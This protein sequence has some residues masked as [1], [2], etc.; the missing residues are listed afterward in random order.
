M[1]NL[2][3]S[4]LNSTLERYE[5]TI[6]ALEAT[7]SPSRE[8]ILDVLT[9]RDAVQATL[10]SQSPAPRWSLLQVNELD[11]RLKEQSKFIVQTINLADWRSLGF[12]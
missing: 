11:N 10:S 8:Q 4:Q 12:G 2:L 7:N 1:T 9:A 5:A 3:S 6:A